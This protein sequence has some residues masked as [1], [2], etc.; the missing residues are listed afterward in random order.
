M[1]RQIHIKKLKRFAALAGAF[2]NMQTRRL[3]PMSKSHSRRA[4]LAGI[5]TAPAL[6]APALAA[7]KPVV[8]SGEEIVRKCRDLS[9]EARSILRRLA[10]GPEADAELLA[11]G[12]QHDELQS[13]YEIASD[14][15][16]PRNRAYDT[17]L[18][19]LSK[20]FGDRHATNEEYEQEL[21][22]IGARLDRDFPAPN[23]SWEDVCDLMCPIERKI[24]ALPA[25]TLQGLAVKARV[26]KSACDTYWD[27]SEDDCDY[28]KRM[29]RLLIDAVLSF[30]AV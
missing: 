17:E 28:D 16:E 25:S 14:L 21:T 15:S 1:T 12:R 8:L 9:P 27:E 4:I 20:R 18:H 13:R 30:G 6:A 22:R 26:A 11:L 23:P 29:A 19:A 10:D 3:L 24:M 7:N 5:A 2:F